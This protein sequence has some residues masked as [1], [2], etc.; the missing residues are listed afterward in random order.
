MSRLDVLREHLAFRW[1]LLREPSVLFRQR[2]YQRD[3]EALAQTL[4]R[5]WADRNGPD[6][7][8]VAAHAR[9][10]ATVPSPAVARQVVAH[11]MESLKRDDVPVGGPDAG[12]RLSSLPASESRERQ[13]E[14]G[15]ARMALAV[16]IAGVRGGK[17]PAEVW[18]SITHTTGVGVAIAAASTPERRAIGVG[19]DVERH[20][21]VVSDRMLARIAHPADVWGDVPAVVRWCVKEAC[22]KADPWA[23]GSFSRYRIETEPAGGEGGLWAFTARSRGMVASGIAGIS[24]GYAHAGVVA[25]PA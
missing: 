9:P 10:T 3:A 5:A 15:A 21:R 1:G 17:R 6:R 14:S 11:L 19:I 4:A 25:E 12:S 22:F 2:L 7:P 23:D 8:R 16:P 20:D 24:S 18:L 13:M